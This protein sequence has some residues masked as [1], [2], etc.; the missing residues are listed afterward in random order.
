MYEEKRA[1]NMPEKVYSKLKDT[2]ERE[3]AS[4]IRK[5]GD[6]LPPEKELA[7]QYR[8]SRS[9]V[10][11]AL[12]ELEK[13][14]LI[15]KKPGLGTFVKEPGSSPCQSSGKSEWMPVRYMMYAAMTLISCLFR[16]PF[17]TQA[18]DGDSSL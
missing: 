15:F 4:L 13:E 12:A 9:S 7:E 11:A 16:M 8:I 17:S 18:G 10:R 6:I 3:I 5:P 1:L 2:L 14:N